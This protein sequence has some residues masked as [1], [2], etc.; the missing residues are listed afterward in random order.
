ML[1]E[2]GDMLTPDELE[3]MKF[4][5]KSHLKATDRDNIKTAVTLWSKLEER[6]LIGLDKLDFLK[7]MLK[8][9]TLGRQDVLEVLTSFSPAED[10]Q[11]QSQSVESVE[12]EWETN[13]GSRTRL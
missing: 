3:K 11:S 9:C 5:C 13:R 4:Y 7:D 6:K 12:S 10:S 8:T 1:T 2:I